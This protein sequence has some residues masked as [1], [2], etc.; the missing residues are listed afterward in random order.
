MRG[1][2]GLMIAATVASALPAHAATPLPLDLAW[3]A[4]PECPTGDAVRAQL[5]RV[6]RVRSGRTPPHLVAVARVEQQAGRWI[7]HLR[8]QRD[9]MAGARQLEAGSCAALVGAA[10]LVLALAFGE[11]VE[12]AD[13][14][15]LLEPRPS[16]PVR[17]RPDSPPRAEAPP[18][19]AAPAAPEPVPPPPPEATAPPPDNET[20]A[21]RARPISPAPSPWHWALA[22]D[23]RS[24]W[25]PMPNQAFGFGAGLDV[26]TDRFFANLHLGALPRAEEASAIPQVRAR[27]TVFDGAASGCVRAG[28]PTSVSLAG[29]VGG[30]IGALRGTAVGATQNDATTAPLYA[31]VVAARLEVPIYQ[32]ISGQLGFDVATAL[33]RPW[34]AV[35]GI[36]DVHRVP[37][38]TPSAAAGLAVRF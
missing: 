15:L 36:G 7:L 2:C 10:T 29:C 5:A 14:P 24:S 28:A 18:A 25:G 26:G 21:V 6:V 35:H 1:A 27:Y 3:E 30:R 20:I 4:P 16:P 12:L 8:T 19:A 37:R 17:A 31:V 9:G 22:L 33:N 13:E 11:G 34:F 38:L 23:G 32:A